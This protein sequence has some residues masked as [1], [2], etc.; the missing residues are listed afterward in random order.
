MERK[1]SHFSDLAMYFLF[2][3]RTL[4]KIYCMACQCLAM[5]AAA[6]CKTHRAVPGKRLSHQSRELLGLLLL[7]QR[8]AGT[9]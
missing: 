2:E 7:A 3:K 4:S 6:S 1:V 8:V 5:R 9:A